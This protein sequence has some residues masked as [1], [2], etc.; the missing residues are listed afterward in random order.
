[1]WLFCFKNKWKKRNCSEV[2]AESALSWGRS[3]GLI[4]LTWSGGQLSFSRC[5]FVIRGWSW[6]WHFLICITFLLLLPCPSVRG[7]TTTVMVRCSHMWPHS[8]FS[9]S[10][11]PSPGNVSFVTLGDASHSS[12]L[13]TWGKEEQGKADA[14]MPPSESRI[15]LHS[16]MPPS[17][18]RIC[19]HSTWSVLV[20][21]REQWS[22]HPWRIGWNAYGY[23]HMLQ[24]HLELR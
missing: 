3:G 10:H 19:L 21:F 15:C 1:M 11:I 2:R 4:P 23:L 14:D 16:D 8:H 17:E 7:C 6:K 13:I 9:G 12:S 22:N 24:C 20:M 5:S 18:S